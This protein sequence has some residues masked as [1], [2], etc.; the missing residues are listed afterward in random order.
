MYAKVLKVLNE[1]IPRYTNQKYNKIL[2]MKVKLLF[3]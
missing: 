3:I 1:L 2:I